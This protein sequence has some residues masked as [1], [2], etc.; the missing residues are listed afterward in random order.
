MR[1]LHENYINDINSL[2][3]FVSTTTLQPKPLGKT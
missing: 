2:A 1:V 3:H